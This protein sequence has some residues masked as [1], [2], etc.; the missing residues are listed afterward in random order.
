[1]DRGKMM[2]ACD[3]VIMTHCVLLC[4]VWVQVLDRAQQHLVFASLPLDAFRTPSVPHCVI[5]EEKSNIWINV[6]N[7][8]RRSEEEAK[9]REEEEGNKVK[10]RQAKEA[11][12]E[13]RREEK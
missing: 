10:G 13:S 1:M 2:D 7:E 6:S 11:E 4:R 8:E 3:Y 12:G 5:R 9:R